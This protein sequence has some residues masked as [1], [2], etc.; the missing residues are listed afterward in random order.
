MIAALSILKWL[1]GPIG[2]YVLIAMLAVG[3]V[4]GV[5]L[6]GRSE[7]RA[8]CIAEGER[9]VLDTIERAG[10]ARDDADRRN[11]DDGRLRDDDA[12]RRD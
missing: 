3:A 1:V 4:S 6:K 10:R 9:D 7:G 8:A 5:Y 12:F 11:A 2:R